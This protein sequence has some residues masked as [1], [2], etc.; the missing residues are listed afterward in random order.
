M[1]CAP[2]VFSREWA[3]SHL[4]LKLLEQKTVCEDK[5]QVNLGTGGGR[6][7][8]FFFWGGDTIF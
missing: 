2:V 8:I 4:H 5:S 7:A 6:A 1:L 3:T